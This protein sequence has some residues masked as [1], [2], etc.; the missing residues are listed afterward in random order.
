MNELN[1]KS[2]SELANLIQKQRGFQQGSG[3]S[4]FR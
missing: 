2:A 4:T 1:Q 3:S